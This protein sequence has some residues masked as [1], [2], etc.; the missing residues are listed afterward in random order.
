MARRYTK[1]CKNL[2]HLSVFLAFQW[3]HLTSVLKKVAPKWQS[4]VIS[5]DKRSGHDYKFDLSDMLLMLLLYYRSDVTQIF[6]GYMFGI[7]AP[8]VCCIIGRH[9]PILASVMAIEK[10]KKIDLFGNLKN[11]RYTSLTTKSFKIRSVSY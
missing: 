10:H 1:I 2:K 8:R 9:E 5:G 4:N 7:D 6:V 11:R 3:S